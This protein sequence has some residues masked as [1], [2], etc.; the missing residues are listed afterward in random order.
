VGGTSRIRKPDF[1]V[2]DGTVHVGSAKLG[3]RQEV[4]ALVTAQ[5]YSEQIRLAEELTGKELGEVFAIV[6]PGGGETKFI[7]HVLARETLH[8]EIPRVVD[9]FEEL[10]E[11]I[12]KALRGEFDEVLKRAEPTQTEAER[13]LR[14][15]ALNLADTLVGVPRRELEKD[16]G[17]HQF[18]RSVLAGQ[19]EQEQRPRILR[20]GAA[21]LFVNQILFYSLLSRESE[22]IG[23]ESY[24]RLPLK[25]A[26]S[27][28]K[29]QTY[30]DR[31]REQDYEPIYGIKV[32][33]LFK[34][35]KSRLATKEIVNAISSLSPKLKS[36]DLAGQ[37][38]QTLI[39]LSIRKPL[40]A[41]YTNPNAA[42]LL[43]ACTV[44][45][46]ESLVLDPACGSGTLLVASYKKKI[47]LSRAGSRT[48]LH[49]KFVEEQVTGIDAMA[50]S[51]HLAAVN[52]ALQQPLLETDHV[53]IG[54]IDSTLLRPGATVP[55]TGE[56]LP[57]EF[58]QATLET[59]FKKIK[60]KA[61]TRTVK[62]TRS[63]AK[64]FTVNS[65]DTIIMNP[66]FT[67]WDNMDPEYRDALANRFAQ[68]STYKPLIYFKPSQQL[69]F[70]FLA[71]IFL[72]QDGRVGAVLPLTTFTAKSFHR[73]LGFFLSQYS[74]EAIFVGLGRPAYSEDTSLTE[75]LLVARK[76]KPSAG[77]RF[78]LTGTRKQPDEWAEEQIVR[79][80][81]QVKR[82]DEGEDSLSIRR[83][84][85]QNE[86]SP[87]GRTLSGLYLS[88]LEEYSSAV[89]E[90]GRL[91]DRS[92]I[93]LIDFAKLTKSAGVEA[94][95][96]VFSGRDFSSYGPK[97]L[98]ISSTR[99]RSIR[100]ET[101]RLF[102]DRIE[103][104]NIVVRDR[105]SGATYRIPA[106][107][108]VPAIRRFSYLRSLDVTGESDLCVAQIT[109][110]IARLVTSYYGKEE[111]QRIL[112][113]LYSE[114]SGMVS[115]GSS[116]LCMMWRV[117]WA[118]RGTTLICVRHEK[119]AFVVIKGKYFTGIRNATQEKL[120]CMWFNS[121]PFVASY[122]GR[123]RITRGTYMDLE[124]YALDRCPV[125]DLSK[126]TQT[127]CD[128]IEELW[129]KISRTQVPS[130][131]EQLRDGNAFRRELDEGML[132]I[133]GISDQQE[134]ERLSNIFQRSVRRNSRVEA[135]NG[136]R[137]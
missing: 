5:E 130:L 111:A 83:S 32:S 39:P 44:S 43:A 51:G 46:A 85:S 13:L 93:P 119:P 40:G 4:A 98:V 16:F 45:T 136:R 65:V 76:G 75:C 58:R 35:R 70:L 37:I 89:T 59:D 104:T 115:R 100:Q 22:R 33:Q 99:E 121:S 106:S 31:V 26:D 120:L 109:S 128:S 116:R 56:A 107:M 11:E 92:T 25:D 30:F 134:R 72:K 71:D 41:H 78:L 101:D 97:A 63:E 66:P 21:F 112:K 122:L 68:I 53:R 52:L 2:Y 118:A 47:A 15:G 79:L 36:M 6:Y 108:T 12:A 57:T 42:T 126:L 117:D 60:T 86:L 23:D 123:A 18:F 61:R 9:S 49:R 80:V 1:A 114:W 103:G 94:T 62:M 87:E 24:P 131:V 133:L 84:F 10:V 27:P 20:L 50:F 81:E 17:G 105:I 29:L 95:E 54:T 127:D 34:G 8:D 38:F 73:F 96:C 135:D 110:E 67:S 124:E 19:I 3:L 129:Q 74:V 91:V 125:P 14:A 48:L 28:E 132:R 90:L 88:L 69:F 64:G 77:H 55:T 102:L 82:L 113:K 137:G 7:L